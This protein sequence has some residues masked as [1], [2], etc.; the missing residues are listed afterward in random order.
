MPAMLVECAAT[1]SRTVFIVD[2]QTES[3][4]WHQ[5][6][7]VPGQEADLDAGRGIRKRE[8]K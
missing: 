7:Y 8:A 2:E 1:E 3:H 6:Q 4:T 5:W